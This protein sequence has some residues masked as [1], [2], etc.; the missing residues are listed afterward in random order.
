MTSRTII[1]GYGYDLGGDFDG[2][3]HGITGTLNGRASDA[4]EI[5]YAM[6]EHLN[7]SALKGAV[8]TEVYG[9]SEDQALGV[10]V[11]AHKEEHNLMSVID[12]ESTI[13]ANAANRAKWDADLAAAMALFGIAPTVKPGWIVTGYDG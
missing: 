2:W 11:L 3:N 9:Y 1:V 4:R 5:M 10:M 12:I 13:T 6:K 7:K 8:T